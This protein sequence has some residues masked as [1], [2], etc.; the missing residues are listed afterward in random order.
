MVFFESINCTKTVY[1]FTFGRKIADH[2]YNNKFCTGLCLCGLQ[3]I[4]LLDA[5][6]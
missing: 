5:T 6:P 3:C 4:I 1:T 2:T